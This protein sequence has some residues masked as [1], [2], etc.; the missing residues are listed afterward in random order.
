[1]SLCVY[2]LCRLCVSVCGCVDV[3][4]GS[5]ECCVYVC[6]LV[7]VNMSCVYVAMCMFEKLNGC[8]GVVAYVCECV[9]VCVNMG[10]VFEC[11]YVC[12]VF[13]CVCV[14]VYVSL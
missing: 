9:C 7:Y 13:L 8:V 10:L 1:M 5:C 4:D 2:V 14:F 3:W 11:V 6:L 12:C